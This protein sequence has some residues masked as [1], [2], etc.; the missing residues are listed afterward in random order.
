MPR[1]Q[2]LGSTKGGTETATKISTCH[3]QLDGHVS[4]FVCILSYPIL[5][6]RFFILLPSSQSVR[7][8]DSQ[9]VRLS[10]RQTVTN[11]IGEIPQASNPI[12]ENRSHQPKDEQILSNMLHTS[13]VLCAQ[14]TYLSLSR[15]DPISNQYSDHVFS[16]PSTRC[17]LNPVLPIKTTDR[18]IFSAPTRSSFLN[19]Y[20]I[21]M[22][23][24]SDLQC[25]RTLEAGYGDLS[26]KPLGEIPAIRMNTILETY[27]QYNVQ[28]AVQ[29]SVYIHVARGLDDTFPPSIFKVT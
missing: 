18:Y 11:R 17:F 4:S 10:D 3:L 20:I 16:A 13:H 21:D 28:C 25:V 26:S 7:Q 24:G 5:Y 19:P 15:N 29:A 14:L 23:G 8:S 9:T 22:R 6:R 1:Y 12:T 2:K 27:V